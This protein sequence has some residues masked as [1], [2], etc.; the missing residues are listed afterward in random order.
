MEKL[1][2]FFL[3]VVL[4]VALGYAWATYHAT[5]QQ[6]RYVSLLA[7]KQYE[8]SALQVDNIKLRGRVEMYQTIIGLYLKGKIKVKTLMS[9]ANETKRPQH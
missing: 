2:K 5:L 4:G 9:A 6:E 8:L 7:Y 1:I 3:V